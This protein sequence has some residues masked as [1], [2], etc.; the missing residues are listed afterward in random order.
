MDGLADLH[1]SEDKARVFTRHV[2]LSNRLIKSTAD[3]IVLWESVV[4]VAIE[5]STP[6]EPK[7]VELVDLAT[8]DY[9]HGRYLL[10][11]AKGVLSIARG[12]DTPWKG[13][14]LEKLMG[15]VSN[16]LSA[17]FLTVGAKR[18]DAVVRVVRAD[19][20]LGTGF[21]LEGGLFVTNH[22]VLPTL[23]DANGTV[24]DLGYEIGQSGSSLKLVATKETF[25]TS[26]EDD[27]TAIVVGEHAVCGAVPLPIGTVKL[28]DRVSIIQHPNGEHKQVALHAN[29]VA[30]VNDERL[31]YFTDT[32]PGSSGS[33]V[34]DL[35]WRWV[36]L[37]HSG[38]HLREPGTNTPVYRNQG[39]TAGTV[40]RG[41]DAAGLR[42]RP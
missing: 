29:K 13:E 21:F 24:L 42:R 7:L 1:P 30:F 10:D 5:H 19:G 4:S 2:G 12:P 28:G 15:P 35:Q 26:E 20:E 37:H 11:V 9:P 32:L 41:I 22:H 38:G 6:R 23:G 8:K 17:S 39:I 34:F 18:V 16:L 31:Q 25:A 14:P 36:G 3:L 33:P 27:W 40:L